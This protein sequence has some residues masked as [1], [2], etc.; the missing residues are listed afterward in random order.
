M[1]PMIPTPMMM[2]RSRCGWDAPAASEGGVNAP[3]LTRREG[4]ASGRRNDGAAA[5]GPARSR[6]RKIGSASATAR[7]KE[8]S[9][10]WE[11]HAVAVA[12]ATCSALPLP[13]K[14]SPVPAL[15]PPSP[16]PTP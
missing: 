8:A 15:H 16:S 1:S 10:C 9:G 12:A 13:T 3:L 6:G 14:A 4:L 11:T 2:M 5:S 7:M